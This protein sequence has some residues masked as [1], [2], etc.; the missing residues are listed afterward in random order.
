MSN[1]NPIMIVV[2]IWP[3]TRR[4]LATIEPMVK[5]N[6]SPAMVTTRPVPAMARIMPV[7]RPAPIS[8]WN[9]A[10]KSRL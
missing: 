5:A 9:R 10:I 3:T 1:S 8:S 4:S 2:P 7:L 6:T